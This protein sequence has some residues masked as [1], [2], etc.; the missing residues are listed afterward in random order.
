M[1]CTLLQSHGLSTLSV[2]SKYCKTIAMN[3]RFA[4]RKLTKSQFSLP[5]YMFKKTYTLASFYVFRRTDFVSKSLRDGTQKHFR[6]VCV[7][8]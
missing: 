3:G 6:V 8:W 4:A 7:C 1:L 5:I 2:M